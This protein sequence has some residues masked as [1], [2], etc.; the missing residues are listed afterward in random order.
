MDEAQDTA[1]GTGQGTNRIFRV[2]SLDNYPD[3][4]PLRL[5]V[6]IRGIATSY[7]AMIEPFSVPKPDCR[8]SLF[9][10]DAFGVWETNE[11]DEP[12]CRFQDDY[13]ETTVSD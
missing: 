4:L 5:L 8:R 11:V 2:H 12:S 9:V 1:Q 3:K 6:C 7:S 10:D 13:S